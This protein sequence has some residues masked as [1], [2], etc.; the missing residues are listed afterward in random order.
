MTII[1]RHASPPIDGHMILVPGSDR[2]LMRQDNRRELAAARRQGNLLEFGPDGGSPAE[3]PVLKFP[4]SDSLQF[5]SP[6]LYE[7]GR[8]HGS[9]NDVSILAGHFRKRLGDELATLAGD[10]L[11]RRWQAYCEKWPK[12]AGL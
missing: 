5:A 7:I 2:K 8:R 10:A 1:L 11:K 6:E 4:A 9:G 3:S 12:P